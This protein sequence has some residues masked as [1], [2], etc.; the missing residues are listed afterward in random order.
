M[1]LF[2]DR[3]AKKPLDAALIETGRELVAALDFA[4]GRQRTDHRIGC[5]IKTCL[6]G[7]DGTLGADILCQKLKNSVARREA[8]AFGQDELLKN[9]FAVQ[10]DAA[11]EAFL[12]GGDSDRKLGCQIITEVSHHHPNPLASAPVDV[13]V[14]WCDRK[15]SER[16]PVMA[17]VIPIFGGQ[18]DQSARFGWSAAALAV[19]DKAPDRVA[20]LK[21]LVRRFRPMTWSGSRAAVMETRLPLL[22]H[23]ELH[24]DAAVAAFAKAEGKRLKKEIDQERERETKDDKANDERF[25]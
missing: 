21:Q 16:Y 6:A 10:P 7:P 12:G 1:R 25:E 4:K 2:S 17:S 14:A 22:D 8:Y 9:L 15:P 23:L 3:Q 13:L 5:L 20:A 24:A 18:E 19:L 11:L